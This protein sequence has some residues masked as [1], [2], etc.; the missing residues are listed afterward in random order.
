[1]P[2][3]REAFRNQDSDGAITLEIARKALSL[4][5]ITYPEKVTF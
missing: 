4:L 2:K 5:E 1:L 3:I